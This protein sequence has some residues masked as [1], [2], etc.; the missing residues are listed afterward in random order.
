[1]CCI[2]KTVHY[3]KKAVCEFYVLCHVNRVM[4]ADRRCQKLKEDTF[5]TH[6][7]FICYL[8][9]ILCVGCDYIQSLEDGAG[10]SVTK[11]LT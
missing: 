8:S 9:H 10:Q 1:M 2:K 4:I 7:H 6:T 11:R 3:A 5:E